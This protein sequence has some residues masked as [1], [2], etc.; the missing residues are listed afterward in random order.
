MH[1]ISD[2][3]RTYVDYYFGISKYNGNPEI[4]EPEKM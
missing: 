1:R 3:G 4:K 2:S